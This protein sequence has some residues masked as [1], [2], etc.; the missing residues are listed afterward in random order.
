[1]RGSE[2]QRRKSEPE[3]YQARPGRHLRL[4]PKILAAWKCS[5]ASLTSHLSGQRTEPKTP[6]IRLG[7]MRSSRRVVGPG[8]Q[9]SYGPIAKVLRVTGLMFAPLDLISAYPWRRA[10]FTTYAL[11][12]YR[13]NL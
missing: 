3:R 5:G 12:F 11:S 1:V 2:G 6:Q 10:A 9:E 8:F 4:R 7:G 13:Q